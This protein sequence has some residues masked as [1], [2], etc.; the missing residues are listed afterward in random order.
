M[1][2]FSLSSWRQDRILGRVLKNS[3]YLFVSYALGAVLTILTANLLGVAEFGILGTVTVFVTNINR[4]FSFR[5]GEMVVKYMGGALARGETERAAAAVKAAMLVE[6]VTS[7]VAFAALALL[8]PLG[9]QYF[10]KDPQTTPLFLLYGISILLNA[11]TESSTGVLQVTNHYRSQAMINFFQ[12]VL[13]AVLLGLAAVYHAGLLEV[14]AVYLFGKVIIGLGPVVVAFHWL[15][16]VLGRGWWRVSLAVLPSWR[17]MLRFSIST[18]FNGT[19]NL[20][21]RD[22]EIPI[23]SFFFGTQAAGYYKIALALINLIVMPINPFISTT[24]PEITRTFANREW[25][26]LRTLLRRVTLISGSWTAFVAMGLLVVGRP[27]LFQPW[28]VLGHTFAVLQGYLPAYPLL[29]V[30]L[31]G[32]GVANIF[33]WNR[34]LLLAQGLAE[35]PLKISFWAM[36]GKVA[37]MFVLLPRA[38]YLAEAYLLSGYLVIS[39][40]LIVWR[41]LREVNRAAGASLLREEPA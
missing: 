1:K 15:P 22:S 35:Y 29:L 10:A 11:I 40:G 37:L 21:A 5:M 17:E 36:L 2:L 18:N 30:L 31:L 8:A 9:A 32:Y 34:P 12:T 25:S 24:Y 16:Q 28:R 33:F 3:S 13:L 7:L 38:G 41:G 26:R 23:V 6:A 27:L 14:L 20:V 19:V 4:L 39:V